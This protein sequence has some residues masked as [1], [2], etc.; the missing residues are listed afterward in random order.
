MSF[1]FPLS[2]SGLQ[3][4]AM[5]NASLPCPVSGSYRV[6]QADASTL[7]LSYNACNAQYGEITGTATITLNSDSTATS[8]KMGIT[9]DV[10]IAST[11][12]EA[13]VT[14]NRSKATGAS[15]FKRP[16]LLQISASRGTVTPST[17]TASR[18]D[19][20]FV[21][22]LDLM[23]DGSYADATA[24]NLSLGSASSD[25]RQLSG[26][27][28]GLPDTR[29]RVTDIDSNFVKVNTP[30]TGNASYLRTFS[31]GNQTTQYRGRFA[32]TESGFDVVFDN[33]ITRTDNVATASATWTGVLAAP[34]YTGAD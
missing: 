10:M 25:V 6:M 16:S 26:P 3:S 24:V 32:A 14:S 28:S 27:A 29:F 31:Q 8:E 9:F 4:A 33:L 20:R 34:L 23:S 22:S 18:L 30:F 11:R 5:A 7:A 19:P 2:F 13:T 21:A 15:D 1:L 12:Y 17:Q